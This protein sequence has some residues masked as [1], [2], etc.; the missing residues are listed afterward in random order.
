MDIQKVKTFAYPALIAVAVY[1]LYKWYM[2]LPAVIGGTPSST[3]NPAAA[4]TAGPGSTPTALQNPVLNPYIFPPP[5]PN[6][7]V[8]NIGGN[9]FG[10][11][12]FGSPA[13]TTTTSGCGCG[14]KSDCGCVTCI[15]PCS[16]SKSN[17]TDGRGGCMTPAPVLPPVSTNSN[18][19]GGGMAF[20]ATPS[21]NPNKN[22]LDVT[23]PA[24]RGLF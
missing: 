15:S 1:L 3:P 19:T 11:L 7:P 21:Y 18:V 24:G 5:P 2:S 6:S 9:T 4:A 22:G 14:G 23:P 8:Y 16:S 10:D 12:N 17:F 20:L 13:P